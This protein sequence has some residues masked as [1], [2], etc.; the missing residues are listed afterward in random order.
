MCQRKEHA[1]H[2]STSSA[3]GAA[4]LPPSE[5][6][7]QQVTIRP[8]AAAIDAATFSDGKSSASGGSGRC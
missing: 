5:G 8:H 1:A 6:T 4:R 2:E 7:G 3:V